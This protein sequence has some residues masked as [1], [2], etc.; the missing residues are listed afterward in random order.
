MADEEGPQGP[1]PQGAQDPSAS[2]NLPPPQNPQAPIVPNA[3]QALE[4]LHLPTLHIPS[5]N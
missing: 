1:V 2:Q 4:A 3:P 5:L